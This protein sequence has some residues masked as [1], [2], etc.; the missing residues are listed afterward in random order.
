MTV[1]I[2]PAV[3]IR[4]RHNAASSS[5]THIPT[6]Q[7]ESESQSRRDTLRR[8]VLV[9]RTLSQSGNR[10]SRSE[11]C[12]VVNKVSFTPYSLSND[13]KVVSQTA[14]CLFTRTA[15]FKQVQE[16]G[17]RHDS[18]ESCKTPMQPQRSFKSEPQ[19]QKHSEGSSF[20]SLILSN[21]SKS[22]PSIL[23]NQIPL[24]QEELPIQDVP[25]ELS[26]SAITIRSNMS[27][28]TSL[29]KRP[30]S[31]ATKLATKQIKQ[32]QQQN[33]P[34]S[35]ATNV[36]QRPPSNMRQVASHDPQ[37]PEPN[38]ISA[39][40][41]SETPPVHLQDPPAIAEDSPHVHLD[42]S[43]LTPM[44]IPSLLERSRRVK[45]A[46]IDRTPLLPS[47]ARPVIQ[48]N[49][50]VVSILSECAT[51]RTLDWRVLELPPRNTIP[52]QPT[53]TALP[54]VVSLNQQHQFLLQRDQN[55]MGTVDE[56]AANVR[57]EGNYLAHNLIWPRRLVQ[58]SHN[59]SQETGADFCAEHEIAPSFQKLKDAFKMC[60]SLNGPQWQRRQTQQGFAVLCHESNVKEESK[61]LDFGEKDMSSV[62]K[63]DEFE[64]KHFSQQYES[65]SI[66][67]SNELAS[68]LPESLWGRKCPRSSIDLAPAAWIDSNEAQGS[69]G[70]EGLDLELDQP[71][72]A[73]GSA[74][75]YREEQYHSSKGQLQEWTQFADTNQVICIPQ[76]DSVLSHEVPYPQDESVLPQPEPHSVS[77]LFKS[78][79][80][81][82]TTN[83]DTEGALFF[84]MEDAF[85]SQSIGRRSLIDNHRSN[86]SHF[87]KGCKREQ[88][89]WGQKELRLKSE[90]N[91]HIK[92]VSSA[93]HRPATR[94]GIMDPGSGLPED[95]LKNPG[96]MRCGNSR[97]R[98][99]YLLNLEE[100]WRDQGNSHT[101]TAISNRKTRSATTARLENN[102][103]DTVLRV[104]EE[105][106]GAA[107]LA[108]VMTPKVWT[109]DKVMRMYE[110]A[111][112]VKQSPSSDQYGR[113]K[114]LQTRGQSARYSGRNTFEMSAVCVSEG[115]KPAAVL[116][117]KPNLLVARSQGWASEFGDDC[118][119]DNNEMTVLEQDLGIFSKHV[120]E[121]TAADSN[122]QSYMRI[123]PN[124]R[125][126][127]TDF[128]AS[129]NEGGA[130]TAVRIT[131]QPMSHRESELERHL[132]SML[133]INFEN[134]KAFAAD[135][136]EGQ[137][138]NDDALTP[139][140]EPKRKLK[141]KRKKLEKT[142]ITD[143]QPAEDSL[144]SETQVQPLEA[145]EP[146]TE[147]DDSDSD[148]IDISLGK[149]EQD[150]SAGTVTEAVVPY[151]VDVALIAFLI[152]EKN[153]ICIQRRWRTYMQA[154]KASHML[155][156]VVYLQRFYRAYRVRAQYLKLQ[157]TRKFKRNAILSAQKKFNEV[158]AAAE[159]CL[160][161]ECQRAHRNAFA[162]VVVEHS[163]YLSMQKRA[164]ERADRFAAVSD[165]LLHEQDLLHVS[166]DSVADTHDDKSALNPV[167]TRFRKRY[168]R[169]AAGL[170]SQ[171]GHVRWQKVCC[172]MNR[173]SEKY[174]SWYER[175]QYLTLAALNS[176]MAAYAAQ[177]KK[178]FKRT[179]AIPIKANDNDSEK[180][181]L[182]KGASATI[183]SSIRLFGD[184]ATT[185]NSVDSVGEKISRPSLQHL[186]GS[187]TQEGSNGFFKAIE[188]KDIEAR[189]SVV[190][191]EIAESSSQKLE[192]ASQERGFD[193]GQTDEPLNFE[194]VR[195]P[196]SGG[197]KPVTSSET[198]FT[199][200]KKTLVK[201][202]DSI[203]STQQPSASKFNRYSLPAR[204][205]T[206]AKSNE[207]EDAIT[208]RRSSITKRSLPT[209]SYTESSSSTAFFSVPQPVVALKKAKSSIQKRITAKS[210]T[211][212]LQ[213]LQAI[214][215]I[216][217]K[218][219]FKLEKRPQKRESKTRRKKATALRE[220]RI[221]SGLQA[222]CV[223]VSVDGILSVICRSD[224]EKEAA[225]KGV[226]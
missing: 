195:N 56:G 146:E 96:L 48:R 153:A 69:V 49:D 36:N 156:T 226:K 168:R 214:Q 90:I 205:T 128:V 213:S 103:D 185:Q 162:Q 167:R 194:F 60:D 58:P 212:S 115:D 131:H 38:N 63:S 137:N 70:F 217:P 44:K 111:E 1:I 35:K 64:N 26:N 145:A 198:D 3:P 43:I 116:E 105:M 82:P 2:I 134:V 215:P 108:S 100:R 189:G 201:F 148:S 176:R 202:C 151:W 9:R 109:L 117:S 220:A 23:A 177:L 32:K 123:V 22:A 122:T 152:L 114:Y 147:S 130:A 181:Q 14:D 170:E 186:I 85:D 42:E 183:T 219:E 135:T 132:N 209:M 98:S 21:P 106:A 91:S 182:E 75:D 160:S 45:S 24:Q 87:D 224:E 188:A 65:Q 129:T 11:D 149:D 192:Q 18:V 208:V 61:P 107:N 197:G 142:T 29:R 159:V 46:K 155:N 7:M 71:R 13:G 143:Q 218:S 93:R 191:F 66:S 178:G 68:D 157:T 138:S 164:Q 76:I 80:S 83:L 27:S 113:I 172:I 89:S 40:S 196:L 169:R 50:A 54:A 104:R 39:F 110:A 15:E 52:N 4:A 25:A 161:G 88:E 8:A 175:E 207:L 141:K 84:G 28:R 112:G 204:I 79:T 165:N 73:V 17:P 133:F 37:E 136:V 221:L 12:V 199:A 6:K 173:I 216:L 180:Q 120:T 193:I 210:E 163:A 20:E 166:T 59:I 187:I 77:E 171:Q 99:A 125:P 101:G 158:D 92:R 67:L 121:S 124:Q 57:S 179:S 174:N 72:R 206:S 74:D 222:L 81:I 41:D 119:C 95:A 34:K 144:S 86:I 10:K 55:S 211:S 200:K 223:H 203:P 51:Q 190:A 225:T 33:H 154:S 184:Q 16:T 118:E 62:E 19:L 30:G 97:P 47:H 126:Q 127:K 140:T 94:L 150:Q 31:S 139:L 53:V 5:T 78:S 102:F